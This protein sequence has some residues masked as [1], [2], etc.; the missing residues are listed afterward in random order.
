[1]TAGDRMRFLVTGATGFLGGALA[2]RLARDGTPVR[3]LVRSER[4]A[5]ALALAAAGVELA[6][7]DV[8][9]RDAVREAVR[10]CSHVVHLAAVR[11]HAGVSAAT[12]FDVNVRGSENVAAAARAE[13]V[14][15]LVFG[16]S[17]GVHGYVDGAL[18]DERSPIRPNTRYR[19]SKWIAESRL[20]DA[21]ATSG[22]PL[23]VARIS[24]VVGPGAAAWL[25]LARGI[26]A[27]RMR[28]LGD[29][30]NHIDLVVVDDLVE[31][32]RLC[33]MAPRVE[34]G[35]FVLGSAVPS[36]VGGFVASIARA[37]DVPV[38]TRGP[39]RAPYR[40]LLRA[41]QSVF[42]V[43]GYDSAFAH[44]REVLAADKRASSEHARAALGYAPAA[45]VDDAVR[46]M[47][48][49]FVDE[50]RVSVRRPA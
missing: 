36:T 15:R 30:R 37:L 3:G 44:S 28:L 39:P 5:S 18:L 46:A 9:D 21:S 10:G 24:T 31:G 33:A 26:A 49:R 12:L 20:R 40:V 25:P 48:D 19:R 14:A 8:R 16:S 11:S 32:L 47:I 27:G 1:M 4:D 34:G 35:C 42:H 41:A 45:S 6:A 22:L 23:V 13:A 43:T 29:G 2:R 50:G 38:P 7:G 17:L